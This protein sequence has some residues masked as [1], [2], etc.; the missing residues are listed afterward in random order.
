MKKQFT[1]IA[2]FLVA[3]FFLMSFS[4][5]DDL[6]DHLARL[7]DG[8]KLNFEYSFEGCYGPYHHG[9]VDFSYVSDTI[10]FV[11][12]S[13]DHSGK[14]GLT[15]SGKYFR[16]KLLELLKQSEKSRSKEI[17]GNTITYRISVNTQEN[18]R[19]ADRIEQQ[20]F[21]Q[22]FQPFSSVF[23]K[24]Q[25]PVIPGLKTGGFVH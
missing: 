8:D 23:S 7:E 24:G 15:Q 2:F 21:I 25:N 14:E 22:L 18:L 19:G 5:I 20:H 6:H 3:S 13:Y 12:T 16:S 17:L 11:E 9:R 4:V 10:F 1:K